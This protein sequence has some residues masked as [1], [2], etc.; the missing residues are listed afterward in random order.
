MNLDSGVIAGIVIAVVIFVVVV[1]FLSSAANI[2][3][4]GYVGVVKTLGEFKSTTIPA[5]RDHLPVSTTLARV[6][7][8]EIPRPAT[9]RKS[10]PRTTWSSR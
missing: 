2:V 1:A 6:D 3:Q 8:R 7:M 9:A 4:Q 10:S 5:W